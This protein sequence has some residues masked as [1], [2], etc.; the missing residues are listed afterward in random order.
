VFIYAPK[1]E[2]DADTMKVLP[3]VSNESAASLTD[4]PHPL[5]NT[6]VPFSSFI[7]ADREKKD[8][9]CQSAN[10]TNLLVLS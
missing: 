3:R 7:N 4:A 2:G 5:E 10:L 9:N 1:H 6:D 8:H